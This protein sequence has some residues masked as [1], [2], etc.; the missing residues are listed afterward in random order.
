MIIS[1]RC[2]QEVLDW[3]IQPKMV[4]TDAWYS[5][6]ENLQLLKDKGLGFLMGIAK[7]RLV[8]INGQKSIQVQAL[9]IPDEGLLVRLKKFGYVKVF[10][11]Q[12]KTAVTRYYIMYLPNLEATQQLTR[13]EFKKY[14][15]IHWGI[16][17]YHRALKQVCGISNFMVRKSEAI[18]THFFSAIRAFTQLELMRAEEVITNWYSLQRTLSLKVAREF[19]LEHLKQKIESTAYH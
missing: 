17:C 12:F 4:T 13:A 15:D 16:E 10:R 7:N 18:I 5:S 3:G 19:I 11:K 14:R 2:A 1:E 9:E 6:Q 8:T